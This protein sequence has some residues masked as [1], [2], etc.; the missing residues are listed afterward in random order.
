ML[1]MA[2]VARIVARIKQQIY[3]FHLIQSHSLF[4]PVTY[5]SSRWY[6]IHSAT[7]PPRLNSAM[8][9]MSLISY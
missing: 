2:R 7:Q 3:F 4:E 8:C 1:L 6:A 9:S 5:R